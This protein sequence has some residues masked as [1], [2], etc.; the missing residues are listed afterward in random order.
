MINTSFTAK[1]GV[2]IKGSMWTC[3]EWPESVKVLGTGKSV[4]IVGTVD[5]YP[6]QTAFMPTG[7]GT[8]MI[9]L[10]KK[11]LKAINKKLGDSVEVFVK[12]TV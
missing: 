5:N 11:V 3:V 7:K 6:I 12:D 8:H 10:N 2:N 4:K 1:I 9:S